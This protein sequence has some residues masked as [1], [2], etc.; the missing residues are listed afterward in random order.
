[1]ESNVHQVLLRLYQENSWLYVIF[2]LQRA[3]I[4][5]GGRENSNFGRNIHQIQLIKGCAR[6][7][8]LSLFLSLKDSPCET[9]K[10]VF[11]FTSKALRSRENQILVF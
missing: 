9:R 2:T 1:M 6:Y 3:I 5:G 8:F 10:K 7:I 11:Y 4:F